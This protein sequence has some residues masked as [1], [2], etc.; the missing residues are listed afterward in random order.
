MLVTVGVPTVTMTMTITMHP[1]T[2]SAARMALVA[3]KA[4]LSAG[5][6]CWQWLR[7]Q[8]I[9]HRE[10]DRL[11]P[12]RFARLLGNQLVPIL[13]GSTPGLKRRSRRLAW[14]SVRPCS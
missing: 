12:H 6:S 14:R 2:A 7:P 11:L 10:P 5:A 4:I 8:P 13:L 9:M 1:V 3:T